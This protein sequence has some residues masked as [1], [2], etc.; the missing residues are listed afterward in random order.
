M[1][2][3]SGAKYK[4]LR[5]VAVGAQARGWERQRESV[6]KWIR[7]VDSLRD[8]TWSVRNFKAGL[9]PPTGAAEYCA[10]LRNRTFERHLIIVSNGDNTCDC[11]AVDHVIEMT[12]PQSNRNN[13]RSGTTAP[14]LMMS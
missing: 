14:Q 11:A 1:A 9:G 8:W 13:H 7:Q 4:L 6:N 2:Q 5:L 12:A 10:L 3:G